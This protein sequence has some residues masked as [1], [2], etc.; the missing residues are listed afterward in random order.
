LEQQVLDEIDERFHDTVTFLREMV[1]QPSVLGN[2]QGV[3]NLVFRR[4]CDIGLF[5]EMWDLDLDVMQAHPLFGDLT[6]LY[7][8]LTYTNRPNVTAVWPAAAPGGRSLILNGHID[9]VSPEPLRDWRHDPW[10]ASTEG[11]WLYGRGAGDMK[12]GVA[13]MLLAV[14]A[15]R[16]AG[17]QLRGDLIVESVIEEESGGNGTLACRLRGLEADAAIVTEPTGGLGAFE[18]T[19]GLFWFRVLVH[20]RSAHPHEAKAGVNAIE[21]MVVIIPALRQLEGRMNADRQHPLYREQDRPINLVVGVI[22]GGDWPSTVAGECKIECRLSFEPGMTLDQAHDLVRQTVIEAAESDPWLREHQPEVEFFGIGAE[23]AITER[24]SPLIRLMQTCHQRVSGEPL[25]L[26][27]FTGSTDQRFFVNQGRMD[28][29]AYGP[30]G[31]NLHAAEERVS[32]AS[33][34]QTAKVLALFILNWCGVAGQ[35]GIEEQEV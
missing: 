15:V 10:G 19:L 7:P 20:G 24:S 14:E 33:I 30:A 8:D 3:Q 32:I 6:F 4:M 12:S 2:E 26:H 31:E 34:K 1:R 22:Q 13:A 16:A 9:V 29:I 18:A 5:S 25:N 11:D 28:A 23:P 35:Q 21:K 27:A 17:V